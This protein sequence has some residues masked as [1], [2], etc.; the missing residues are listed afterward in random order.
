MRIRLGTRASALARTQSGLVADALIAAGRERG[1]EVE[2]EQVHVV[3]HGDTTT[4]SLV[5]LSNVGVFVTAL[6]EALLRGECDIV[7]HSLKDMPVAPYPGLVIAAYPPREDS[8]D[9]L[10]AGGVPWKDLAPGSRVGTSS[11][12]RAAQLLALRPDL[13]VLDVRGNVDTRLA[14]VGN[15]F[16]AVVL[17]C[18]GLARLGRLGEADHIFSTEEMMPAP[19]Q[20]ALAVELTDDAAPEIRSLV[21]SLDHAP[22][23][24]AV[25]AERAAL[26]VLD[27]GCSAPVG[28]VG[29]VADGRLTLQVRVASAD[30]ALQMNETR[31]GPLGEGPALGRAAAHTLLARGAARLMGG[32]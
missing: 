5:G 26:G 13:V 17:A 8:R 32:R 3:T 21:E 1:W 30:G 19:G 29:E 2:V 23:S 20:G 31:R 14:A 22:T 9:A 11:P 28:A 16:D 18:A 4:G 6:R 25:Q 7:V 10:C 24:F 15:N 27:A 12:R